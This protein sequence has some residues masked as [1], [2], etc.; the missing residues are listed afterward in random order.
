MPRSLR[1]SSRF[2]SSP[3]VSHLRGVYIYDGDFLAVT[4]STWDSESLIEKPYD[5]NTVLTV[6][7]EGP[8]EIRSK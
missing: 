8:R 6:P 5:L 3:L 7:V 4:R 2:A 1:F